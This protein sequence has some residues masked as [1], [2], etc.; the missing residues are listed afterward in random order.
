VTDLLYHLTTLDHSRPIG[1]SISNPHAYSSSPPEYELLKPPA[2]PPRAWHL[3]AVTLV[4]GCSD[5]GKFADAISAGILKVKCASHGL[6]VGCLQHLRVRRFN[7]S[8]IRP[9]SLAKLA[10]TQKLDEAASGLHASAGSPS[11][12]SHK[13]NASVAGFDDDAQSVESPDPQHGDDAQGRKRPI[14]RA[15]NEC[16]QQKVSFIATALRCATV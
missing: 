9:S 7:R 3:Q 5:E 6:S 14:K 12:S 13:R 4:R 11:G 1:R 16:R 2:S 15:C 10:A 8:I